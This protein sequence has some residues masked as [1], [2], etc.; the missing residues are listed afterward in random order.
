MSDFWFDF[1]ERLGYGIGAVI[2]GPTRALEQR[3]NRQM[4]RAFAQWL[5]GERYTKQ[6]ATKGCVRRIV[7]RQDAELS[8]VLE[9]ELHHDTKLAGIAVAMEPLPERVKVQVFR[10]DP[11][12]TSGTLEDEVKSALA[13]EIA[14]ALSAVAW[15]DIEILPDRFNFAMHAPASS[16][17]WNA[18]ALGTIKV[19]AWLQRRFRGG[20]YR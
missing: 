13:D 3:N 11:E 7:E 18:A 10:E 12:P 5:A 8:C 6:T 20:G 1:A 17:E 14:A 16:D 19:V 4:R 2:F 9:C 15:T